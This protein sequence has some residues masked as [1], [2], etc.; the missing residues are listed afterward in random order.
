MKKSIWE[1]RKALMS[2]TLKQIKALLAMRIFRTKSAKESQTMKNEGGSDLC[3]S[4]SI[5]A[6]LWSPFPKPRCCTLLKSTIFSNFI[7]G[8]RE[9]KIA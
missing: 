7:D 3:E 1:I 5:E 4:Y 8:R 9:A 6:T 2:A